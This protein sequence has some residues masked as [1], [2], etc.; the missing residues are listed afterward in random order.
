[1]VKLRLNMPIKRNTPS[2]IKKRLAP[3]SG[4]RVVRRVV[5]MDPVVSLTPRVISPEEKRQLI[6]AHASMR[7]PHDPLQMMSLWAGVAV[8][9]L[10]LVVGYWYAATPGFV[11]ASRKP[12]DEQ[13]APVA[14]DFREFAGKMKELPATVKGQVQGQEQTQQTIEQLGELQHEV[15]MRQRALDELV[16][17]V[18]ATDTAIRL[19]LFQ[20]PASSTVPTTSQTT[21]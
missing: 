1:V 15:K 19:D 21:P 3:P 8:T 14:D 11:E 13:L 17:M 10:V 2:P 18:N 16:G 12:F 20:P 5:K 6:L 4:K 7:G 9:A